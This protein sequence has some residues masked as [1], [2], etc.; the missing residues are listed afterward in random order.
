MLERIKF[1]KVN[2][3]KK[4]DYTPRYYD[5]RKE[6]IKMMQKAYSEEA[7]LSLTDQQARLKDKMQSAWHT[8]K[9]FSQQ[10]RAANIR[11]III[12]VALLL[13]AYFILDYVDIFTAEVIHLEP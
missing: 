12:L 9:S 10:S 5:A 8:E 11:L 2:R 1:M 13:G 4:F 7:Q 6:R 3:N